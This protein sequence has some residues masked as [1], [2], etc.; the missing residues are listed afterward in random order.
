MPT[1]IIFVATAVSR[2]F[3]SGNLVDAVTLSP[4]MGY[5]TVEPFL[6]FDG[7]WAVILALTSNPSAAD[8]EMQRLEEGGFLYEKVIDTS[9]EW[10]TADNIMYVVGATQARMLKGIRELVPDHFLLVPGVGA[11]GGSLE[12][13]ARFGMNRQ[14]GLLVNS[15]RGIIYA[16]N[17][18][19]FANAAAEKAAELASQMSELL[20]KYL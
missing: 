8:F 10:G 12:E 17:T 3:F 16:D 13:V 18:E 11:Q 15:S 4:Y 2:A 5:D 14:C 9:K 19:R 20:T 1:A 7:K 6:Q